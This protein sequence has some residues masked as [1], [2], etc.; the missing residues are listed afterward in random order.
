MDNEQRNAKA[1]AQ[2]L[3]ESQKSHRI[4]TP[5]DSHTHAIPGIQHFPAANVCK[6]TLL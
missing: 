3:Q 4:R 2:D 5:G 1:A 6:Y